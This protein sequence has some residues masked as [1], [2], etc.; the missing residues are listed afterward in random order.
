MAGASSGMARTSLVADTFGVVRIDDAEGLLRE[1][2]FLPA[3]L[4]H[5]GA[6]IVDPAG[7]DEHANEHAEDLLAVV[8]EFG[9]GQSLLQAGERLVGG[10]LHV[11][12]VG[13]HEELAQPVRLHRLDFFLRRLDLRGDGLRFAGRGLGR[14]LRRGF[15]AVAPGQK[16][17][18][19]GQ[20]REGEGQK[21]VFHVHRTISRSS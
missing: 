15:L 12:G 17:H 6:R 7:I 3:G 10:A 2:G 4:K 14:G 5:A 16:R 20:R 18:G 19:Q 1:G 8:G 11:Q 9:V 13:L 21:T